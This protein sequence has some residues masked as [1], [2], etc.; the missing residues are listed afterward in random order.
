MTKADEKK[1]GRVSTL[2]I[3]LAAEFLEKE[4]AGS[5]LLTVT[6]INISRDRKNMTIL[7]TVFPDN[8]EEIA[9]GFLKRKRSEF[10]DYVKNKVKYRAFCPIFD[11]A[12]DLGEKNR[13]KIDSLVQ[14]SK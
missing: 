14:K 10:R 4:S 11:F 3:K 12:I 2:Y 7:I 6:G 13:Q 9:L 8:R 1:D 5:E